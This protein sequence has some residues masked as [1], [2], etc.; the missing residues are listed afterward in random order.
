[1]SLHDMPDDDRSLHDA[2]TVLDRSREV[3]RQAIETVPGERR[4]ERPSAAAWSVAEVLEHLDL[5]ERGITRLLQ[6]SAAEL[7][8][9][10]ERVPSRL[11]L[12]LLADRDVR[13]ESVA[14]ALPTG[15]LTQ[16]QAWDGLQQS[17]LDLL[18]AIR[19]VE[20]RVWASVSA[21]H[22]AL[23][24]LNGLDWIRFIGGHEERHAAQIRE[25]A[26]MFAQEPHRRLDPR[27][28]S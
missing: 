17:R 24:V 9:D 18:H 4:Q 13:I 23:G 20:P 8:S 26:R 21:P 10:A 12:D 2:I 15:R 16:V 19:S 5:V 3:L 25:A 7:R 14:A 28:E 1:M 27:P 11:N 22:F 6:R